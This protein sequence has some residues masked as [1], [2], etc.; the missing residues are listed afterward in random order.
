MDVFL[1]NRALLR[2]EPKPTL[3]ATHYVS[4]WHEYTVDLTVEANLA[5]IGPLFLIR[6]F[7]IV[8]QIV[9]EALEDVWIL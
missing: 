1:T 5:F 8:F 4:A 7:V 3:H 6:R 2:L 9:D